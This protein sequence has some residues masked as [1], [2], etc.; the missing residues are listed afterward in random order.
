MIYFIVMITTIL[1]LR[2]I[3]IVFIYLVPNH[4]QLISIS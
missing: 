2:L 1:N 4:F 3:I